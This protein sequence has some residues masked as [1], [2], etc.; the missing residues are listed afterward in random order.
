M[1]MMNRKTDVRC[2][3]PLFLAAVLGVAA[4]ATEDVEAP[5]DDQAALCN[6]AT[7]EIENLSCRLGMPIDQDGFTPEEV[8]FERVN[9]GTAD[10]WSCRIESGAC[11]SAGGCSTVSAFGFSF[12][13][14]GPHLRA[15]LQIC[16]GR[17]INW[18]ASGC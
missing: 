12:T 6:Q 15:W 16:D 8:Q 17:V 18:G 4:C 3:M 5:T 7:G 11:T 14:C 1:T 13:V 9:D 2:W 10:W